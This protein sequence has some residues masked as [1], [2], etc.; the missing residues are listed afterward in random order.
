MNH[1]VA[2]KVFASNTKITDMSK[3]NQISLHVLYVKINTPFGIAPA[4]KRKRLRNEPSIEPNKNFQGYHIF[5]NFSKARK[6]PKPDCE[7]LYNVLLHGAEK[8]FLQK[9][10]KILRRQV[11]QIL[12]MY[13]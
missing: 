10:I 6:W 2:T 11:T 1:K 8:I 5:R 13:D 12:F 3:E 4:W 7:N 9:T